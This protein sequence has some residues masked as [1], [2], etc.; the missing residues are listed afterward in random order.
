MKNT[1]EEPCSLGSSFAWFSYEDYLGT[2]VLLLASKSS[3]VSFGNFYGTLIFDF[4]GM[5]IFPNG[6]LSEFLS[7]SNDLA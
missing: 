5:L 4:L 6:L 7:D 3:V 2:N 1:K